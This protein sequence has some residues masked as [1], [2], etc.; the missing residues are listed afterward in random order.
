MILGSAVV[1]LMLQQVFMAL[2][3]EKWMPFVASWVGIL[4][5]STFVC[6]RGLLGVMVESFEYGYIIYHA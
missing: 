1:S 2:S 3:T 5:G 4:S 6:I